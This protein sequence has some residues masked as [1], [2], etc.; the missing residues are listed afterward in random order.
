MLTLSRLSF[1]VAFLAFLTLITEP[2]CTPAAHPSAEQIATT[3]RGKLDAVIVLLE[4]AKPVA[5]ASADFATAVTAARAA[6]VAEDYRE[7]LKQARVAVEAATAAGAEVP[8][9]VALRL[10]EAEALAGLL[11]LVRGA[12]SIRRP[13]A[14]AGLSLEFGEQSL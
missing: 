4:R 13:V 5:T 8:P 7:A 9:E 11:E 2:G 14:V 6:Y 12:R 3:V 10:A 1:L